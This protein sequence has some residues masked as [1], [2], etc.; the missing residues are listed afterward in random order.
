MVMAIPP[1]DGMS[2]PPELP[3]S[4]HLGPVH[5]TVTDLERSV[6]FYENA[7]G[8]R[9]HRR[10]D[11]TAVLGAGEDE[12]LVLVEEPESRPAAA[13]RWPDVR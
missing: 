8:L 13:P 4:L 11:G 12:L 3:A 5:L 1:G 6:P 7:I 2:A 9:L 10:E